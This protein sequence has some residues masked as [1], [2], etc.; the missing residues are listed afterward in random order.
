MTFGLLL[1]AIAPTAAIVWYIYH[2]DKYEPEPLKY[3]ILA[4]VLGLAS[5]YPATLAADKLEEWTMTSL[6]ARS[7]SIVYA[8]LVISLS[9]ELVKFL[10]LRFFVFK[11]DAFNEPFDG[12]VYGV[13]LGM[14]F[15]FF[16]N[17]SY[18]LDGGW[19]TAVIRMFTAVPAH[20]VFGVVM[21]YYV[22]KAKF[23][24]DD[25][26]SFTLKAFFV[27][28]FLHGMYDWLLFQDEYPLLGLGAFAGLAV[29][30]RY[31]LKM[32]KEHQ[33]ASPF[34]NQKRVDE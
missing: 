15:A 20:A 3:L 21:G 27:P 5:V 26:M 31:A 2:K 13:M 16:E 9:E 23:Q 6:D 30:V 24:P 12:I 29:S 19:V 7:E 25:E 1:L 18:V 28:F 10:F 14:G 17:I 8:F 4:F 22:G 33:E 34:K 11:K 32:V